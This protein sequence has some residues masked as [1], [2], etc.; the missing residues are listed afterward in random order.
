M[1]ELKEQK[2]QTQLA[3][4]QNTKLMAMLAKSGMGGEATDST[5]DRGKKK[6]AESTC[7]T[8]RKVDIMRTTSVSR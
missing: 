2:K 6:K 3:L 8:A 7:K 5:C 1:A 4:D